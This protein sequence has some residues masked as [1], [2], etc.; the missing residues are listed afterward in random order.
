MASKPAPAGT[1]AAAAGAA[2][3]SAITVTT[4]RGGARQRSGRVIGGCEVCQRGL[5]PSIA[6]VVVYVKTLIC[7]S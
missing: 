3:P 6:R 4:Q 1:G 5:A 2:A 7:H